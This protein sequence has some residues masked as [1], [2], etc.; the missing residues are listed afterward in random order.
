MLTAGV[1][2]T[3]PPIPPKFIAAIPL[4]NEGSLGL[5]CC[6]AALVSVPPP[7]QLAYGL[8]DCTKGECNGCEV[9]ELVADV[10]ENNDMISD[11]LVVG[12]EGLVC[13]G[14]LKSRSNKPADGAGGAC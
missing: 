7:D 4:D 6:T 5:C 3:F 11:F 8:C 10:E 1:A 9:I 2:H 13:D 12:A 14:G